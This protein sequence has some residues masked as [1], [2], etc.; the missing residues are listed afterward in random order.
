MPSALVRTAKTPSVTMMKTMA[1]TTAEVAARPTAEAL[2]P[3]WIPRMQPQI[4]TSTPKIALLK[5]PTEKS[6]RL[7]PLTVAL[8]YSVTESFSMPTPTSAPPRMP[9]RS[10]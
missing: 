5:M 9:M 8:T 3:H 10:A 2:R 1:V 4:A 6:V 7:M